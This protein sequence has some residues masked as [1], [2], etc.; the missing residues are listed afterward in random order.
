M[1][2]AA[3]E[4]DQIREF[5]EGSRTIGFSAPQREAVTAPREPSFSRSRRVGEMLLHNFTGGKLG[6][7]QG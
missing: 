2:D 5:V 4:L 6:V 1:R 3:G 7:P